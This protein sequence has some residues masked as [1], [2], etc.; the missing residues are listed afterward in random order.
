LARGAGAL[1]QIA[2]TSSDQQQTGQTTWAVA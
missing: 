1:P 2:G